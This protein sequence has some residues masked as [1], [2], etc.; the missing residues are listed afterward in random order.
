MPVPVLNAGASLSCTARPPLGAPRQPE[1]SWLASGRFQAAVKAAKQSGPEDLRLAGSLH[2]L[3]E[4][5]REVG[6][7]DEA[8]PLLRQALAIQERE[9]GPAHPHVALTL[10]S[11]MFLYRSQGKEP[12]ATAAA[13]R[14]HTILVTHARQTAVTG[15]VV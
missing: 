13:A 11:L 1:R 3:A 5:Y 6:E 12:E 14:V 15:D 9:L 8:E 4:L 10:S 2:R 7:N